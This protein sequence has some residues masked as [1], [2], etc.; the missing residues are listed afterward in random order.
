LGSLHAG[1]KDRAR[2]RPAIE[3][4]V[5]RLGAGGGPLQYPF[6]TWSWRLRARPAVVASA[7]E[8]T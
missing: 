5:L 2:D 1:L 4:A 7:Y 3:A 8:G 6:R